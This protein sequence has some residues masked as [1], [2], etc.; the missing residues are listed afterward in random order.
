MNRYINA[1]MQQLQ[2]NQ[3]GTLTGGFVSITGGRYRIIIGNDGNGNSTYQ[4]IANWDDC[5]HYT[6]K[7]CE[8]LLLCGDSTNDDCNNRGLCNKVATNDSS[9]NS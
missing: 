6:N 1:N 5:R 2:E 4:R 8:N 3:D 9:S 7:G